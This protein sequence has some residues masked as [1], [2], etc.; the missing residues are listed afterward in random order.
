MPEYGSSSMERA[1]T[2]A[3]IFWDDLAV[4]LAYQGLTILGALIVFF[5]KKGRQ[6]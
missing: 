4:W 1:E 5:S 2:S 3:R 6:K